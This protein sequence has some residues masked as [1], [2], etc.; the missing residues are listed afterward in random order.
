MSN[1]YSRYLNGLVS[2][3]NDTKPFH[4]KLTEI[5]E[6]YQFEESMNV[7]I[8]EDWSWDILC[9]AF[10][11]YEYYSDGRPTNT[12]GG[13]RRHL[14][15]HL[16]SPLFR[17]TSNSMFV[18]GRDESKS[19]EFL[20]KI[21][22]ENCLS[23]SDI[24]IKRNKRN[25]FLHQGLDYHR[26]HGTYV[27]GIKQTNRIGF[28]VY[29]GKQEFTS[30]TNVPYPI[31]KDVVIAGAET[32]RIRS[33]NA[34]KVNDKLIKIL[35]PGFVVVDGYKTTTYDPLI[36]EKENKDSLLDAVKAVKDF[37]MDKLNPYSAYT[38]IKT[39]LD[40]INVAVNPSL[41]PNSKQAL[42]DLYTKLEKSIPTDFE[43]LMV[44]VV[45]ENVPLISG[46][47]GWRGVDETPPFDNQKYVESFLYSLSPNILQNYW[48][49][50][51]EW[52]TAA[53]EY[54]NKK[55]TTF[56]VFNVVPDKF[57]QNFEEWTVTAYDAETAYVSGSTSEIIGSVQLGQRFTSTSISFSTKKLTNAVPKTGDKVV[58]TPK[59]QIV[60]HNKAPLETWSIVKTD[61][62]GYSRPAISSTRFPYVTDLQGVKNNI[63]ILDK[64]VAT[65]SVVLAKS[66]AGSSTLTVIHEQ[67]SRINGTVQIGSVFNNGLIAF[68]VNQGSKYQLQ[69]DEIVVIEIENIPPYA[70]ELSICYTYDCDGYDSENSVYNTVD[71]P[72][73]IYFSK[74]EFGFDGKSNYGVGVFEQ[75]P[76]NPAPQDVQTYVQDF[77]RRI[78]FGY[79]SRFVGYDFT[80]FNLQ[81][82]SDATSSDRMWRLR[83]LPDFS[84]PLK[85]HGGD[86]TNKFNLRGSEQ[87]TN[88]FAPAK[89]D[90]DDSQLP[91][92]GN[93]TSSDPD[94][95]A[96]LFLYYASSF[97][98]EWYDPEQ[99]TWVVL[100]TN[101]PIN[102]AYVNTQEGMSFTIVPASKEFIAAEVHSSWYNSSNQIVQATTYGGDC[103]TWTT[104]NP[105][106]ICLGVDFVSNRAPRILMHAPSFTETD[107]FLWKMT[108]SDSS[109]YVLSGLGQKENSG[110]TVTPRNVNFAV[111]GFSLK[112]RTNSIH[113]TF[114]PNE[115]G[116]GAGDAV[117]FYTY[118]TRPTYLVHGSV[119][120][121]QE[122][123]EY[124]KYYWNG[125][126]GFKIEPPAFTFYNGATTL[127][128][129]NKNTWETEDGEFK[130]TWSSHQIVDCNYIISNVDGRWVLVNDGVLVASGETELDDGVIT[131]SVPEVQYTSNKYT[132][133]VDSDDFDYSFG[134]DVVVMKSKGFRD[135]KVDDVLFIEKS[136]EEQMYMH[137]NSRTVN[138]T[139]LRT[140]S[141][142]THYF[143]LTTK[144]EPNIQL[145]KH[146]PEVQFTSHW[147]PLKKTNLDIPP[148][149][150]EFRDT[151][152]Q[153]DFHSMASGELIGSLSPQIPEQPL[154][155][156]DFEFD[157]A[158]HGKYL[159]LNSSVN[160]LVRTGGYDEIVRV[161]FNEKLRFFITGGI[162][163][164]DAMF[165]DD[166][167]VSIVDQLFKR[168]TQ[169][170]GDEVSVEIDDEGF[171]GFLPGYDN[172]PLDAEI[173][174]GA[175][176]P[177]SDFGPPPTEPTGY[178]DAGI[179]L[180]D[181]FQT[182]K[183][184][185]L[186]PDRDETQHKQL[187]LLLD[188]LNPWVS[189]TD[190]ASMSNNDL[191]ERISTVA[192][193]DEY[194]TNA[195]NYAYTNAFGTPNAGLGIDINQKSSSTSNARFKEIMIMQAL[196][197]GG[198]GQTGMGQG[199]FDASAVAMTQVTMQSIGTAPTISTYAN[200]VGT[201]IS[202]QTLLKITSSAQIYNK[203]VMIWI[204]GNS[205]PTIVRPSILGKNTVSINLTRPSVIKVHVY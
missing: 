197:A 11:L 166:F 102:S 195:V 153:F 143:D 135:T 28:R 104:K 109:K 95:D 24:I 177:P 8:Q 186:N 201:E 50:R 118:K 171:Q 193:D 187:S 93:R 172:L 170:N 203:T 119:S 52:K 41:A 87:P 13:K 178:Y 163:G 199:G 14:V 116:F 6:I 65:G 94:F 132:I 142:G 190:F 176:F 74:I 100:D 179:I 78:E 136:R 138:S 184:L 37:A 47:S 56:E 120:G 81:F 57:S 91:G 156:N 43:A 71:D 130:I 137:L 44:Y 42:T 77:L 180:V 147:M 76:I 124:N 165:D 25:I 185:L 158:S 34:V 70:E 23:L 83:A 89:Y 55:G 161:H 33:G 86:P 202:S 16:A 85:L 88:P 191:M 148:S 61:P 84:K 60:V 133:T 58:L 154:E 1:K 200:F 45:A 205:A 129:T 12:F 48:N 51:G 122:P 54:A 4:S 112:D 22:D 173:A 26:S 146:S 62:F 46:Y 79:D 35:G 3:I 49:D 17:G 123:A 103:I 150:S 140:E 126:I 151:A 114:I 92:E 108:F 105:F 125:K 27:F 175:S 20:P 73:K 99:M 75:S 117:S 127:P 110:V 174:G 157:V 182:A 69:D 82:V 159:P 96:D 164:L 72:Y 121:W 192:P 181:W 68:K 5:Q 21:F 18:V 196:Q 7:K 10:W 152:T 38:K 168:I 30:A 167:T 149:V 31:I 80:N 189:V 53:I 144:Q 204:S 198:I 98:L 111:D 139:P 32:I 101:V 155:G 141:Q 66:A 67:D 19:L 90:A 9:K 115:Y 29:C 36:E 64:T 107:D 59:N 2:Y 128:A 169:N 40:A 106:P 160:F 15:Q 162:G 97:A 188:L 63:T 145:S 131:I 183:N 134:Q 194:L 113:Y 39:V